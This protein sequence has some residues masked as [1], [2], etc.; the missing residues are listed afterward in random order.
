MNN[1]IRPKP[2]GVQWTDAQWSAIWARNTDILVSAAAGSGK[3]AVLVERIIQR[4]LDKEAPIGVD[5][6]L[7][8]TFTEAAAK[9]M[10]T[11]IS[12]A[13]ERVSEEE[14]DNTHIREQLMLVGRAQIS[15]IHS[16]CSR[17]IRQYAHVI[18]KD[19]AFRVSDENEEIILYY[20]TLDALLEEQFEHDDPQFL[21]TVDWFSSDRSDE[22]FVSA[23]TRLYDASL[24]HPDPLHWLEEVVSFYAMDT[25]DPLSWRLLSETNA[26]VTK[27]LRR[28]MS[29]LHSALEICALPGG[30]AS[31][32]KAI[33]Q[34][35]IDLQQLIG[36]LELHGVQEVHNA[37][38]TLPVPFAGKIGIVSKKDLV[39]EDLKKQVSS[40]R[41]KAKERYEALASGIFAR[42]FERYLN[43]FNSMRP[44]AEQL[45]SLVTKLLQRMKVEK[46]RRAI[47]SFSDLEHDCLTILREATDDPTEYKPSAI[48]KDYQRQFKELYIDE[49]QDINVVQELLLSLVAQ[50]APNA[51]N[52]FMVGDVKQ[53]IYGF[54]LAEPSLFIEKYNTFGAN[55]SIGMRIDLSQ[56]FRSRHTVL[57]ATNYIF[58]RIMEEEVGT[59]V[60]DDAHAL[61]TT[62]G[63][64]PQT[65]GRE[66]E[67]VVLEPNVPAE[68]DEEEES[69][70]EQA[71]ATWVARRIRQL[72]RE[73]FEVFDRKTGGMRPI[74]ARDCVILMRSYTHAMTFVE[75]LK[76]EGLI[77]YSESR[78]GFFDAIEVQVMLNVLKIV[79]NPLQDIPLASV[80]RSPIVGLSTNDLASIRITKKGVPLFHALSD[81][82]KSSSSDRF[83]RID[84]VR[85][86]LDR[87]AKWRASAVELSL[88]E[89]IWRI[90]TDTA[91]IDWV[92]MLPNGRERQANL[93]ALYDRASQYE[94]TSLRGLQRFLTFI[95]RIREKEQDWQS[96]ATAGE[97][98]DVVRIMTIHKSKGLEF[99]VVFVA[100]MGRNFNTM[101]EK[102]QLLVHK[103]LGI[104]MKW[105]DLTLRYE[106]P[107]IIEGMIRA[108]MRDE[109]LA[110]ELRV[111]YVALTRAKE[112]LYLVTTVKSIE[113]LVKDGLRK[114]NDTGVL[115]SATLAGATSYAHWIAPVLLRTE[116]ARTL[117]ESYD[118]SQP[119][120]YAEVPTLAVHF[121]S[122]RVSEAVEEEAQVKTRTLDGTFVSNVSERDDILARMRYAYPF[123]S[124]VKQKAKLN[125]SEVKRF[126][127]ESVA[128]TDFDPSAIGK[129][130]LFY[131]FKQPSWRSE[132][133]ASGQAAA[134]GTAMHKVMQHLDFQTDTS[135]EG[136]HARIRTLV[137][138][139]M[140]TKEQTS[141]LTPDDLLLFV[142][143]P[144][145]VR[146]QRAED[147]R[148]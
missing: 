92:G 87:L 73:G 127:Q 18:D 89:L 30:P 106:K 124:S 69:T 135:L 129:K 21:Q 46:K 107:T 27:Q 82:A 146:I 96:V 81:W 25:R 60:Y 115:S 35:L 22:G 19:P 98:D 53:S 85:H 118:V 122:V 119:T 50:Q 77:G 133:D 20:E 24:A 123:E 91:Y 142:Q 120:V 130:A 128:D 75:A 93:M 63:M 31:Y 59:I 72:I 64:Y 94:R 37:R 108:R 111:L 88:S 17:V 116:A 52:R 131:G 49:F 8:V 11:R 78:K 28:M 83:H 110:E 148:R 125:V 147:I 103:S 137:D 121:E 47:A 100:G 6:L 139:E 40:M 126:M 86:F 66:T 136:I 67:W 48:A 138:K 143:S 1:H 112:K 54:R 90:Y 51:G 38:E 117:V 80:L 134:R 109:L 141:L 55:P 132:V 70:K 99:P 26:Y 57:D 104:G 101:D 58:R 34:D 71:E 2:E 3:T 16:F 76:A 79:D 56:N 42:P 10:R 29:E 144:L 32:S 5:E 9:E 12:A 44:V 14:P 113:G 65:S 97:Q 102:K 95:A 68:D 43:D 15:T 61:V 36:Y 145:G 7:I 13:L 23:I 114:A 33:E 140:M 4:L 62:E 74:E 105:K 84:T 45:V 39:D 41:T